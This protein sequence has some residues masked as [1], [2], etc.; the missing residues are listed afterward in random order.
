LKNLGWHAAEPPQRRL[1][2]LTS[3]NRQEGVSTVASQ[4]GITAAFGSAKV[5]LIDANEDH[6][7]LHVAFNLNGHRG[8]TDYVRDESLDVICPTQIPNLSVMPF[9]VPPF[10]ARLGMQFESL[11]EPV[12]E[13]F[14]LVI[15][16]LP[17]ISSGQTML[18]WAP[19]LDCLILVVCPTTTAQMASN[20]DCLVRNAGGTFCGVVQNNI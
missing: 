17:A 3:F 19:F 18:R 4:L 10:E 11:M 13:L 6:P 14:D 20:A 1:L 8:F 5:L 9:G 15:L 12:L 2:A 16:D 7:S